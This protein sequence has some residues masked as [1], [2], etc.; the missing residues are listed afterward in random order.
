M[1]TIEHEYY[2]ICTHVVGT[3]IGR[4]HHY[5]LTQIIHVLIINVKHWNQRRAI[6]TLLDARRMQEGLF[7]HVFI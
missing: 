2:Y 3:I 1:T 5:H 4:V 6:V 7:N